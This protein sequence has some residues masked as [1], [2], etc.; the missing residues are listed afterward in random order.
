MSVKLQALRGLH[1]LDGI[2]SHLPA[3]GPFRP[4]RDGFSALEAL[5]NGKIQGKLLADR[6][7]VGRC[8]AGSMTEKAGYQQNDHQPWPVFWT[9]AEDARLVGK[10]LHWRDAGNR[11][12]QEGVYGLLARRRLGE[13]RLFTQMFPGP[14]QQ[15]AG[16]WTSITSNWNDCSNYYHW[17]LDGLTRLSI[18][19]ELP[20]QTGILLPP[21]VPRFVKET[22]SLLGL[23]EIS[24]PAAADCIQPERYYFCAPMAMTGVWNPRGYQWLRDRFSGY[25]LPAGSASPVFLTRRGQARA[26]ENLDRIERMLAARGFEIVD[27]GSI[28]VK[29]QIEKVSAATAICGL[30]GAAMTNLLWANPGTPVIEIFEEG[31]LNGCYEQI[32]FY[33]GLDY[34][35]QINHG[36]ETEEALKKWSSNLP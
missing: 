2:A 1:L 19:D 31:Y 23:E 25:F 3:M 13:D 27:C 17:I 8:P 11:L 26:P 20:E 14:A 32:A 6:Q 34:C 36:Q 18:R 22:L 16:A 7:A 15:M 12:C 21:K 5:K 4:L 30:H 24:K 10:M 28:P 33:N 35:Y 29:S 9:V